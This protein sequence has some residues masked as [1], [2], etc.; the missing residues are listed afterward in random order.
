MAG[1]E[2]EIDLARELVINQC[3]SADTLPEIEAATGVLREWMKAHPE[4]QGMRAGFEQMSKIQ[5]IIEDENARRAAGEEIP[6]PRP[7]R[8]RILD[9]AHDARTLPQ[10]DWAAY[11]L[12]DWLQ[13]HSADTGVREA[14]AELSRA[15]L[16]VMQDI[17]AEAAAG[18]AQEWREPAVTR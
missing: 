10:R 7:E 3:L 5:E 11:E 2:Y 17:P 13:Q 14:F 18:Q 8:E 6:P 12:W 16:A 1:T 4:E 9:Q 15:G